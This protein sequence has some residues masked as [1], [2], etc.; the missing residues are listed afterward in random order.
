MDF[1]ALNARRVILNAIPA[2]NDPGRLKVG[3]SDNQLGKLISVEL[4]TGLLNDEAMRRFDDA[5]TLK[6]PSRAGVDNVELLRKELSAA[7]GVEFTT[8]GPYPA[9]R[10]E[11]VYFKTY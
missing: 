1:K 2:W 6:Y 11:C 3:T 10:G 9:R 7:F 5:G 8:Q 4:M